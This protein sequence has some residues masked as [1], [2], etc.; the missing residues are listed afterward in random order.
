VAEVPAPPQPPADLPLATV[1]DVADF[2]SVTANEV[3]HGVLDPK[4]GNCLG[5][6]CGQLLKAI[7]E[8]DL[9]QQLCE[10]EAELARL[11]TADAADP[12]ADPIAAARAVLRRSA[13]REDLAAAALADN[14]DPNAP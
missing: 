3:R 2:L 10:L 4:V 5:L 14:D 9:E 8:G 11:K 13:A 1:A 6:L 12:T 7:A